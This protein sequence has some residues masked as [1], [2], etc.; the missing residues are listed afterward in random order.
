MPAH[1]VLC[2]LPDMPEPA[3]QN[4][5]LAFRANREGKTLVVA[6]DL[7]GLSEPAQ[8]QANLRYL[9]VA[10]MLEMWRSW[11]LNGLLSDILPGVDTAAPGPDVVEALVMQ[12]CVAP[13]SKLYAQRWFPTTAL[14]E[15]IGMLPERFNNTRIHRVLDELHLATTRIQEKLPD[16]YGEHGVETSA[17]F[18]DVTDTF[19]EGRGCEMA[20]RTRTKAGHRNKWA[21]GIVLLVNEWG[22]PLRWQ[23]VP[24]KTKD[25][26]AM[27]EMLDTIGSLDWI[28]GTPLIMDRAMGRFS[29]LRK[30]L[31]SKLHF[32]TAVPVNT[33]ETYT[34]GLPYRVF[35]ELELGC[36]EDSYK[37]DMRLV[38]QTAREIGLE[39][40]D[41]ELFV[42]E[43][44][45]VDLGDMDRRKSE[46]AEAHKKK[47]KKPISSP[48][49]SRRGL[50]LAA[51]IRLARQLQGRLDAGEFENQAALARSM[52]LTRAR[53][54]QIIGVL[55]LAPDIQSR[56]L[57]FPQDVH[58]PLSRL[59][60]VVVER[61]HARQREMLA[62]VLEALKALEAT[63]A[64]PAGNDELD[65]R[66]ELEE[67]IV[68]PS[69]K[70][71]LVAYFNPRMFVDQRHR[72]QQHLDDIALFVEELNDE[73]PYAQRSRKE[74]PTRRKIE[75]KL[76]K[77]GY[78]DAFDVTLEPI[79]VTTKVGGQVDSFHC[80]VELKPDC[81]VRRRRYDGFVLLPLH[82][83]VK[84]T[85]REVA[86]L[87]R[88]K[89]A[90]EKDFQTIKSVVK[91]RPIYSRTDPKVQAHVTV[92][93]L[94]LL[95]QRTLEQQLCEANVA[96]STPACL[97]ILQTCHLNVMKQRPAGLSVYSVTEPTIAQREIL[98]ALGLERLTNDASL[99]SAI[100][101]RFVST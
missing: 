23:V 50:D 25:H 36:T 2:S 41:A 19:F 38:A 66:P 55:R 42:K 49:K 98:G 60:K 18:I 101:P 34:T 28:R 75:R 29:S 22:Y 73:L 56:L 79:K 51:R 26:H 74:P 53:V 96:L 31:R 95:L 87:Y 24:G 100:S 93:M 10:V 20:R 13:G 45:V 65:N 88:A 39:E 46:T 72:A 7:H 84:Q 83:A 16:L 11:G 21:I 47:E 90:I 97:E 6:E 89:D 1:R 71:R 12:R 30:L 78:A 58:V 92:C 9:D 62:D 27:G 61:D 67:D 8:V 63:S 14:P 85:A 5:K 43:V 44:G 76:E 15:F 99:A 81:W 54:T 94:A 37:D 3:F 68:Q 86:L 40:V 69:E 80:S 70:L 48:S 35:S 52:G 77:L 4:L 33:I 32:V 57:S 82:P 64:D 91:M 59:R 17:F